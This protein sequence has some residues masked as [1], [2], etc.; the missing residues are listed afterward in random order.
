MRRGRAGRELVEVR[1]PL[2][3]VKRDELDRV[4]GKTELV[5]DKVG[6]APEEKLTPELARSE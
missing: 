1:R 3:W 4:R 6:G 5:F 2:G